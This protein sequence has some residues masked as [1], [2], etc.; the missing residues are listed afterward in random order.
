MQGLQSKRRDSN[1]GDAT[2]SP[3]YVKAKTTRPAARLPSTDVDLMRKENIGCKYPLETQRSKRL[4]AGSDLNLHAEPETFCSA[5][6]SLFAQ[7][8]L[9]QDRDLK[10]HLTESAIKLI[11]AGF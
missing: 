6:G 7:D 5:V 10:I 8:D 1:A 4:P 9:R 11:S 3:I 2:F